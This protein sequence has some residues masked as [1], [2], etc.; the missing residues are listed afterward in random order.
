MLMRRFFTPLNLVFTTEVI[1]VWLI[2]LGYVPRQFAFLILG[3]ALFFI[4]TESLE[5]SLFFFVRSIPFFIAL[6]I[7]SS[8]DSLNIWRIAAIALFLKWLFQ[9]RPKTFVS[10]L[11]ISQ[12]LEIKKVGEYWNKYRFEFLGVLLFVL[13][14]ISLIGAPDL[15]AGVKRIIYFGNLVLVFPVVKT[16]VKRPRV[17]RNLAFNVLIALCLVV[18]VGYGQLLSVYFLNIDQFIN[19]WAGSIQ[20]G[21]YGTSWS[22]IVFKGNTW[23]AYPPGDSPR[24]RMFSTMPSS[25][26]FPLFLLLGM[27]CFLMLFLKPSKKFKRFII[28]QKIAWLGI[29][30]L[31]LVFLGLTL[32]GTR[33]IWAS[34]VF[35]G[36]AALFLIYQEKQKRDLALM[37][38]ATLLLLLVFFPLASLIFQ[39]PQF[40]AGQVELSDQQTRDILFQRIRSI[41]DVG[42]VSNRGRLFI[43]GRTVKS[44]FERPLFGVGIGNFPVILDQPIYYTKAGSSAHNLYLHIAAEMGLPALLVF[45]LML[46]ELFKRALVLFRDSPQFSRQVFGLSSFLYMSW[47]FGYSLTEATL[48]DERMFLLF[49]VM[50]GMVL[51]QRRN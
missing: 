48:F 15:I 26:A 49:M 6:P 4:L 14:G 28:S 23:F 18:I 35:P 24:L 21:F 40:K 11:P 29:L 12:Y 41:V 45:G 27:P 34:L 17:F 16:L 43:W 13:A 5:N 31:V 20:L 8:F 42:E 22:N 33:G 37:V 50:V 46:G 32:S 44:I 19:K 30:F 7:T 39:S 25:H 51:S 36:V 2:A 38:G 9:V 3:L 10:L 47:V 1:L